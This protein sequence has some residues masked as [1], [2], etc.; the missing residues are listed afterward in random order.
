[1]AVSHPVG[2]RADVIRRRP[3]AHAGRDD[4]H[5]VTPAIGR[6]I[7]GR[8]L[9]H[10]CEAHRGQTEHQGVALPRADFRRRCLQILLTVLNRRQDYMAGQ[11]RLVACA[12]RF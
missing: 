6:N 4:R 11:I 2:Q 5:D 9:A 3:P 7:D 8:D 1:M 10:V 12:T